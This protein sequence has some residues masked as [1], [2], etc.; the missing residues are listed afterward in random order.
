MRQ[1]SCHIQATGQVQQRCPYHILYLLP[2]GSCCTATVSLRKSANS[3]SA[4][5]TAGRAVT[6]SCWWPCCKVEMAQRNALQGTAGC[7]SAGTAAAILILAG[8]QPAGPCQQ[9]CQ[10]QVIQLEATLQVEA[11]QFLKRAWLLQQ[12]GHPWLQLLAAGQVQH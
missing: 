2:K 3:Y 1:Q 10:A 9:V 5:C 6:V 12:L 7:S 11:L 4:S 8:H